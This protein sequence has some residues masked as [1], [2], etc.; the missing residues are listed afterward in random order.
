ML[1]AIHLEPLYHEGQEIISIRFIYCKTID[2][3]LK[4]IKGI[5]WNINRSGWYIPL[6]KQNY[7]TLKEKT[8]GVATLETSS[9]KKYLLQRKAV[10]P[11]SS[12]ISKQRASIL[13]QQPLNESN[14]KAF[15]HF[16][17]LLQLKGY[18]PSTLKTYCCE[19]HRLLRLLGTVAVHD[20]T[21]QH[22]MSY[23]LWLIK[24][25][26]YSETH[27]HTAVNAIKF[28][29]EQVEK[30][31]RE[32]YDLPRPKKPMKLP[33]I[34]AEEEMVSLLNSSDNLK[35]KALL[36]TA[37]SAGLRVSELVRLK[38]AHVDS[39]RMMILIEQGKGKKDRMVPLSQRLLE[40]L[41]LYF[42]AYR[43]TLYLFE[44][45]NAGEPISTRTAQRILATTK[46]RAKVYKKGS[47]H[48]LRHSYATHLLEGGTDIRY[49]KELLGHQSLKT[50]LIYT[51]V[52]IKNIGNVQSPLDKLKF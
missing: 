34:L 10:E 35:H 19:F 37:Y 28:Y 6:S 1:P 22:I 27:V 25:R 43:P 36:M 31:P 30:R 12:S 48:S 14:L 18:S 24:K 21:K 16:Q 13:M 46:L 8:K 38:I 39:K 4:R 9:L 11:L 50:T 51:H 45:D 20:L 32:F 17:T 5:K 23:L 47:I 2:E 49:I 40:T 26:K 44:G 15:N 3:I 33:S 29:F 41:R 42:K 52:S 7:E